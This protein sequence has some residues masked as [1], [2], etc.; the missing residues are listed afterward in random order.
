MAY[1]GRLDPTKGVHI[2]LQALCILPKA[3]LRLDIYGVA[4]GKAGK[5][6]EQELKKLS[7][8]DARITFL[9]PVPSETVVT[10]IA[11]YDLLAVPSQ[12]LETGPLV[13]LESF[14]AKVPV[15]GSKLGGIAELVRD[16]IDG[17]LVESNSVGAWAAV[18]EKAASNPGLLI[19]LKENVR[20]PRRMSAVTDEMLAL[21]EDLENLENVA[22]PI[23]GGDSI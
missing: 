20:S 14:A 12:C 4:Q 7:F 18:L 5:Q 9:P 1:F 23:C 19:A 3:A 16:G 13:V 11:E 8:G 2:L 17:I 22:H 15:I 10:T 6:Y 21:F